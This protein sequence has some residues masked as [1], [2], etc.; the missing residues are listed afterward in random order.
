MRKIAVFNS[1]L[2]F[3]DVICLQI[4]CI[5]QICRPLLYCVQICVIMET[6]IKRRLAPALGQSTGKG[7]GSISLHKQNNVSGSFCWNFHLPAETRCLVTYK[8]REE[9]PTCVCSSFPSWL[10]HK[11]KKKYCVSGR[12][13]CFPRWFM[14]SDTYFFH[15]SSYWILNHLNPNYTNC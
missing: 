15:F 7:Q 5:S 8:R 2:P 11:T 14:C 3:Q 4:F 6:N 12:I 10:I 13:Y 1:K 9:G